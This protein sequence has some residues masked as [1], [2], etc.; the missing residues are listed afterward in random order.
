MRNGKI[1]KVVNGAT[2]PS[3]DKGIETSLKKY[4][5]DYRTHGKLPSVR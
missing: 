5:D 3:Y 2:R 1:V 4:F